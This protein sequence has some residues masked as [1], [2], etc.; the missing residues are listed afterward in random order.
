MPFWEP[1]QHLS[2]L[3]ALP[4]SPDRLLD[5]LPD[6]QMRQIALLKMEGHGNGEVAEMLDLSL[7][8]VER[9]LGLIRRLWAVRGS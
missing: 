9:R 1:N 4:K 7:R 8:T 5:L 2:L 6:D 3:R